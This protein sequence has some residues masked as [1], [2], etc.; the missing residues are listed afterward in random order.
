VPTDAHRLNDTQK[1][2]DASPQAHP[3]NHDSP[4]PGLSFSDEQLGMIADA[5]RPL[6]AFVRVAFVEAVA[7]Y[8]PG[9]VELGNGELGCAL[10]ELQKEFCCPPRSMRPARVTNIWKN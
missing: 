6:D 7:A 5:C 3:V 4:H 9:R 10:R 2:G 1:M 8:F